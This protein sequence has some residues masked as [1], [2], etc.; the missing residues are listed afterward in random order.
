M[1]TGKSTLIQILIYL[2]GKDACLSTD[3]VKL[4]SRLGLA[5]AYGK[6]LLIL[7]DISLL[8]IWARG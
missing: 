7:N 4:N 1:G 6:L 2:L 8:A 5:P 3:I